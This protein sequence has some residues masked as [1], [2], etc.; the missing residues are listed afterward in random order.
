MRTMMM[1]LT[2]KFGN[3]PCG[4]SGSER[5]RVLPRGQFILPDMCRVTSASEAGH[6][7]NVSNVFQ[8]RRVIAMDN[9]N[10]ERPFGGDS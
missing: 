7:S 1:K 10:P 2:S 4:G 8:H 9:S 3:H 6:V 5:K